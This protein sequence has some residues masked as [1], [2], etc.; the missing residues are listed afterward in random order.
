MLIFQYY[1]SPVNVTSKVRPVCLPSNDTQDSEIIAPEV[2]GWGLI[3]LN[4]STPQVLQ[5]LELAVE[6]DLQCEDEY[7]AKLRG[8][9]VE[10]SQLCASGV[11]EG[12]D[13]CKGD[14]GGPLSYVGEDNRA[15][16]VGVTSFGTIKCDSSFPGV[17]TRVTVNVDWIRAVV[18]RA[19]VRFNNT[20]L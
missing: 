20:K 6:D 2:V 16:I 4:G 13:A 18:H 19:R 12:T 10:R 7:R 1:F 3:D 8:F 11:I 5:K 14:S 9:F 17:Y 15:R